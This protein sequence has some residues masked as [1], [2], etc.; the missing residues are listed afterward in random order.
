MNGLDRLERMLAEATA[1]EWFA[2]YGKIG[3][4]EHGI[5]EMDEPADARLIVALR[6]AA[7]EL[8]Q[9]A[10]TA[11]PGHDPGTC[12]DCDALRDALAALARKLDGLPEET[13]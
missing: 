1:A 10:R 6:N 11:I 5:G 2:D 9:I 13:P 4:G 7:P 12:P 3:H 8:I